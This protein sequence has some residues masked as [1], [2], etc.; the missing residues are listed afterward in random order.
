MPNNYTY[1]TS[2]DLPTL[3]ST[4]WVNLTT[5]DT[6]SGVR[7]TSTSYYDTRAEVC[8]VI[9]SVIRE[10]QERIDSPV[11]RSDDLLNLIRRTSEELT[12]VLGLLGYREYSS[13]TNDTYINH[14]EEPISDGDEYNE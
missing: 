3:A 10:F 4:D 6:I 2:N 8:N 9:N 13:Y 7:T 5:S 1:V 11:V 14:Q 12:R